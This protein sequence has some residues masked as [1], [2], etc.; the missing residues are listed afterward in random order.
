MC[1]ICYLLYFIN[2]MG[3]MESFGG[4]LSQSWHE[5]TLDLQHRILNRM[6][7]L[8]M[9]PVLPAFAGHVPKSLV[10]KYPNVTFSKQNWNGFLPT[11]LLDA[12]ERLFQEIGS[13]FLGE[14]ISEF[15]TN[16]V[17]NCD[18]YNEMDPISSDPDYITKTGEAIYK[19]SKM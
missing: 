8:G 11:Y 17:Y 5:F 18:T 10:P 7:N 6:R 12:N 19:V 4:P 1:V 3:N 9:T 14:Y 16:H 2:R 13:T 15:G